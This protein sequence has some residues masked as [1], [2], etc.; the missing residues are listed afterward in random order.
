MPE[1]VEVLADF[2]GFA[3]K[4]D[5]EKNPFFRPI[6]VENL[7]KLKSVDLGRKLLD[8]IGAAKPKVTG[9]AN[10]GHGVGINVV[11][12]P[13]EIN[14][15]QAGYRL[16]KMS[17]QNYNVTIE[18]MSPSSNPG[19]SPPG[20]SFHIDGGS[21]NE[22]LDKTAAGNGD[23]TVCYMHF[24][25]VQIMTRKGER[26][27]PYIVLAQELIHSLHALTGVTKDGRDEE[28]WTS[29]ITPFENEPMSENGF[30][31]AFK[32]PLRAQYF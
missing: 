12:V 13:T 8:D 14:M 4:Y 16:D 25:N 24:S 22:A 23:G 17:D 7:R 1:V 21:A 31:A 28:R 3:V 9:D 15:V 6:M 11:G 26:A 2:P 10:S 32:L 27:D 5:T 18:G 20:C 29:G 30:R 19:H